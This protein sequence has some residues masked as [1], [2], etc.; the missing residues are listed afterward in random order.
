MTVQG[1]SYDDNVG[2]PAYRNLIINGSFVVDQRN[3]G[4]AQ[5][6]TAAGAVFV[7]VSAEL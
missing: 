7:A 5:T 4:A 3:G 1:H 2:A 6:I